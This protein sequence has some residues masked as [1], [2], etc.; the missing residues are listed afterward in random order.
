MTEEKFSNLSVDNKDPLVNFLHK[1][2]RIGVKALAI[3]MTL[4]ILWGIGDV[5]WVVYTRLVQPPFLL[6]RIHDILFIF[7]ALEL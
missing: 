1:I 4:V 3:L 7:G 2:I 6:L 5:I